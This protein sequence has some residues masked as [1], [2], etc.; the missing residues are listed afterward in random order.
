MRIL[1]ID[2]KEMHRTSAAETLAGHDVTIVSSFKEGIDLLSMKIDEEN[3]SRLLVEVG[4]EKEPDRKSVPE[5]E[6]SQVWKAY[7]DA[8]EKARAK[9]IIPLPFEAV[10]T[11]M[12]MPAGYAHA[13]NANVRG[14][15]QVPFGF[16]L[17]LKAAARGAKYVALVTDINHHNSAMSAGLDHLG[18]SYWRKGFTPNF[19]INGARVMFVHAPFVED[20]V[21]DAPCTWCQEKPGVCNSCLGSGNSRYGSGRC[22]SCKDQIG[23]CQNCKGT[24]KADKTAHERKDWGTVLQALIS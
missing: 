24:T 20:V 7:W 11:D 3:V 6:W 23:V 21:K 1:V 16:I 22:H 15:E 10:L 2:D 9:S 8:K 19:E 4:F 17:A 14:D 13:A 5:A 18:D 12:M